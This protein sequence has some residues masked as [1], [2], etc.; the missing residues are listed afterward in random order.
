M[1]SPTPASRTNPL[2]RTLPTTISSCRSP[3]T[4]SS[5]CRL[6]HKESHPLVAAHH[7]HTTTPSTPGP[8]VA[9][10]HDCHRRIQPRELLGRLST[11]PGR[12]H[13]RPCY[14]R[15]LRSRP[16]MRISVA[17]SPTTTDPTPLYS[18]RGGRVAAVEE[19]PPD[20]VMRPTGGGG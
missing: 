18:H 3:T 20:L 12:R 16:A 9:R 19:D 7:D 6:G 15:P 5:R 13:L 14:R 10:I 2:V 4:A 17:P 11:H 1:S 8:F